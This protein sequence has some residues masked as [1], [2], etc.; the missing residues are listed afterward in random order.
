MLFDLGKKGNHHVVHA[1]ALNA[2]HVIVREDLV[3]EMI[4]A[5]VDAHAQNLILVGHLVQ[6]AING[7]LADARVRCVYAIVNRI[8]RGM[9][10]QLVE[11]LQNNAFL[12]GIACC[13]L[14]LLPD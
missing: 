4:G 7:C 13:H 6:N 14:A 11:R 8:C 10:C 1:P 12:Y 2:A 3:V 9:V 5:V